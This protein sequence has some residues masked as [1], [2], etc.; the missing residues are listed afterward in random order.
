MMMMLEKAN[1]RVR[2]AVV[3]LPY[4]MAAAA[5]V[6]PRRARGAAMDMRKEKICEGM[7]RYTYIYIYVCVEE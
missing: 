1:E 3:L 7:S 5:A 4:W 2:A 6:A